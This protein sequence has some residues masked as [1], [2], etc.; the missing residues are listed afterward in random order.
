MASEKQRVVLK[1]VDLQVRTKM[2]RLLSVEFNRHRHSS[3]AP[4]A[5]W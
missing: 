1:R 4:M 2:Q 3:K 5:Q